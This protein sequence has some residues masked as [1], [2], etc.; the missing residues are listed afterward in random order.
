MS[1]RLTRGSV[2][3]ALIKASAPTEEQ[4]ETDLLVDSFIALYASNH[5]DNIFF[6]FDE[7][8]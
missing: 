4:V 1:Q 6:F 8:S 5:F 2:S 7:Q 3:G